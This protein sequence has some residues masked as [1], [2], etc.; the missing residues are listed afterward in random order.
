[1]GTDHEQA[2]SLDLLG[3]KGLSP[4]RQKGLVVVIDAAGGIAINSAIVR[5]VANDFRD[6]RGQ[7]TN[8]RGRWNCGAERDCPRCGG[9]GWL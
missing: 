3:D 4:L 6:R 1:M 2:E 5:M 8:V 9:K 7:T